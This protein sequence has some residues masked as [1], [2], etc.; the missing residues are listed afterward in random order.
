MLF[1]VDLGSRTTEIFFQKGLDKPANHFCFSEDDLLLQLHPADEIALSERR[2]LVAENVV[3][4]GRVEKE[5]RQRER[6]QKAFRREREREIASL[7]GDVTADQR[8]DGLRCP[9]RE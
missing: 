4:R 3:S 5:I 2:A 9:R 1:G 8:I 7:K 6:H